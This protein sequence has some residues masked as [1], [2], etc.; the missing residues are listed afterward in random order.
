LEGRKSKS[1]WLKE[2]GEKKKK[3]KNQ[4]KKKKVQRWYGF[5]LGQLERGVTR[6]SL[7]LKKRE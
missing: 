4:K 7:F 3:K 5:L 6:M 2:E 1:L